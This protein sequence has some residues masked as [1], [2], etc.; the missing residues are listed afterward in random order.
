VDGCLRRVPIVEPRDRVH[1][2]GTV[3]D[4]GRRATE[5]EHLSFT[6]DPFGGT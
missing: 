3:R 6:G 4:S 2:Q 5:M 1:L